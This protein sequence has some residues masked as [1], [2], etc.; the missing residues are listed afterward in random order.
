MAGKSL[1]ERALAAFP[2]YV[3][4]APD[5]GQ[6]VRLLFASERAAAQVAHG[7]PDV[8]TEGRVAI[9][10]AD[11][12]GARSPVPVEWTARETLEEA[13]ALSTAA[14]LLVALQCESYAL[15]SG[16]SALAFC[17]YLAWPGAWSPAP[18]LARLLHR[19]LQ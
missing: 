10:D 5:D 18:P 3:M 1:H 8:T 14:W 12:L 13:G 4:L 17:A 16:A 11:A 2:D 6:T 19:M 7:L 15:A 9:F